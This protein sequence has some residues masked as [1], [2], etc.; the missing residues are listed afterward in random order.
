MRFLRQMQAGLPHASGRD[1]SI[2][3][4]A[5]RHGMHPLHGVRQ[6]L[7]QAGA[8]REVVE[9]VVLE[10]WI[11]QESDHRAKSFSEIVKKGLTF[12]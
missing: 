6:E 4:A 9:A 8:V 3:R 1:G 12:S 7:P 2:Q 11:N 10:I 5:E